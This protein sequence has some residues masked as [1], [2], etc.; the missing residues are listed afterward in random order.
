MSK[1]S[2]TIGLV[3]EG[4]PVHALADC[5]EGPSRKKA[6]K[7]DEPL[8][9]H[10]RIEGVP[11][12]E[13]YEFACYDG[14]WLDESPHPE[15]GLRQHKYS[16]EGRPD[17]DGM[18]PLSVSSFRGRFFPPFKAQETAKKCVGRGRYWDCKTPEEVLARWDEGRDNGTAQHEHVEFYY[19][20]KPYQVTE[21]VKR[22]M[23]FMHDHQ[24]ITCEAVERVVYAPDLL[25]FG[26]M[27]AVVRYLALPAG[28]PTMG[29][30][31]W[32]VAYNMY[33][34]G[35]RGAACTHPS[36]RG[37]P[38]CNYQEYRIS[39]CIYKFIC[40]KYYG[41]HVAEMALIGLHKRFPTY[42]RDDLFWD[43]DLMNE[44]IADRLRD[45]LVRG[46]A[47]DGSGGLPWVEPVFGEEPMP[48]WRHETLQ[49]TV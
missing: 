28:D 32:K 10:P 8:K 42:H 43:T 1:R 2:R 22:A 12:S 7:N 46:T 49:V 45:F 20:G 25:L 47:G 5:E 26:T 30:Y 39:M 27:D 14:A 6:R 23:Q 24:H 3:G 9:L 36:T 35:F 44:I 13:Q 18:K 4:N 40:E 21:E 48:E 33:Y 19:D 11:L 17:L 29:I 41:R 31:D 38:A 16:V 37:L 15:T 34:N